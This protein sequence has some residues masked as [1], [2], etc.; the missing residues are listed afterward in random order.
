MANLSDITTHTRSSSATYVDAN[1][2]LQTAAINEPR[3]GHHIYNGSAWVDEGYFH[4]SEARTNLVTYSEDFTD[5]SWVKTNTSAL[6]VDAIGPDGE[7]SAVTLVDSGAGGTGNVRLVETVTTVIGSSYTF[8][9]FAKALGLNFLQLSTGTNDVETSEEPTV[10]VNLTDGTFTEISGNG[11]PTLSVAPTVEPYGD[12]WYRCSFSFNAGVTSFAVTIGPASSASF[13]RFE[14]TLA[15]DG[16][17]SIL[18]YG[19]QFEAGST[20][21]SYIP[22]SGSTVT[23]AADTMTIP[24][25]NMPWNPLAVSIQMEGTMT[26]AL[27]TDGESVVP[28]RWHIDNNNRIIQRLSVVSGSDTGQWIFQQTAS[29]VNDELGSGTNTVTPG[30]NVP[31]N[32]ASRH[33]STFINGAV[34]GTALTADLTPTALP[35]LSATDM[36]IGS[37]FMGT[38]KLFRVWADDLTDAG[39]AE[40]SA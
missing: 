13:N 4:E 34:D 8:S 22:T 40:A 31:F 29:A 37:D 26:Y 2:I 6:F 35:D 7:T 15:L 18:I 33:G 9:V 38:I 24:A 36:Q 16:T 28:T 17:S 10:N 19:A 39:I 20:P 32:I 14:S 1:G 27:V 12:G 3:V 25:V 11:T 30:I 23:R 21:S 5:A